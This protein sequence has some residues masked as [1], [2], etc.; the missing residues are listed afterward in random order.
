MKST[1]WMTAQETENEL[2]SR[3]I[4]A[5]PELILWHAIGHLMHYDT[6]CLN[7]LE[8]RVILRRLICL[9]NDHMTCTCK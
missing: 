3:R 6:V 2:S 4:A 7:D 9:I 8:A 5:S 1:F